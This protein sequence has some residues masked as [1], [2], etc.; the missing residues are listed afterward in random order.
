[1]IYCGDGLSAEQLRL[2]A[3]SKFGV[4]IPKSF[5]VGTINNSESHPEVT[6]NEAQ[7]VTSLQ[8]SS[9]VAVPPPNANLWQWL[10]AERDQSRKWPLCLMEECICVHA[11]DGIKKFFNQALLR[12]E[13]H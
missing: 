1:M 11:I 7:K 4:H 12:H 5:E 9:K 2:N 8:G 6:C 3:Q 13:S 10:L